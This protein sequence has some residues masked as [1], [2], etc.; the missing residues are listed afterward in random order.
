L[1]YAQP[2]LDVS[3]VIPDVPAGNTS[4]CIPL[5]G[6]LNVDIYQQVF[7]ETQFIGMPEFELTQIAFRREN[8]SA[9]FYFR[10]ANAEI[11]LGFTE[12]GPDDLNTT[13]AAN[14][15]PGTKRTVFRGELILQSNGTDP[16]L[17]ITF[18]QGSFTV[19][20]GT[21]R[22]LLFEFKNYSGEGSGAGTLFLDAENTAGD[23][24]SSIWYQPSGTNGSGPGRPNQPT[25]NVVSTRGLVA[26][27]EFVI[28]PS[29]LSL[30]VL[31]NQNTIVNIPIFRNFT[32][33]PIE[34]SGTHS[35][36]ACLVKDPRDV[37][38]ASG[39]LVQSQQEPLPWRNA[40][41]KVGSCEW[42]ASSQLRFDGS[43][44]GRKGIYN[45]EFGSY[46][47]LVHQQTT[48][49]L[50]GANTATE[51]GTGFAGFFGVEYE[52]SLD[53]SQTVG[54]VRDLTMVPII[55]GGE[56][57]GPNTDAHA[58]IAQCNGSVAI[59]PRTDSAFPMHYAHD[60][61]N[62]ERFT[63]QQQITRTKSLIDAAGACTTD[64]A[65]LA[66]VAELQN[67][68]AFLQNAFVADQYTIA[69]QTGEIMGWL[70]EKDSNGFSGCDPVLNTQG[71][72]T[73]AIYQLVFAIFDR[74]EHRDVINA[75]GRYCEVRQLY[76]PAP[77]QCPQQPPWPRMSCWPAS[78]TAARRHRTISSLV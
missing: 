75:T 51:G 36:D 58:L 1:A 61:A 13:F 60:S 70:S 23:A 35:L 50:Q 6:C 25:A 4:Q 49:E 56:N 28:D 77:T 41:R 14:F 30:N 48:A 29:S 10:F 7:A 66:T 39:A 12:N 9:P 52:G 20:P 67:R 64:S 78:W 24:V 73:A 27:F 16:F 32:I 31:S 3:V 63:I 54:G 33:N 11:N 74:H 68:L 19:D 21:G 46:I 59:K 18:N 8:P 40:I 53:C 34:T 38:A 22:H 71:E 17:V 5:T 65:A 55:F 43:Q 62:F 44:R 76:F 26:K 2:S 72:V 57:Q 69:R 47:V 37:Y 15:I 42:L 45:G